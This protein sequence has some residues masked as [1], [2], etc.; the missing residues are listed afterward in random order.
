V[1]DSEH[2]LSVALVATATMG[3]LIALGVALYLVGVS[4]FRLRM[5]DELS[6]GRLI[7][8]M[9]RRGRGAGCGEPGLADRGPG[10]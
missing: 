8:V 1:A 6:R 10:R 2:H 3:L 9:A 5:L 4:A 7:P